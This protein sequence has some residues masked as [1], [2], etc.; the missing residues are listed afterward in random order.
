M[1]QELDILASDMLKGAR[2]IAKFRGE[3]ERRTFDL[4]SRG[5]I[6]GFRLA[7]RWYST[8]SAQRRHLARME[9]EYAAVVGGMR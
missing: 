1:D 9:G 2:Q 3:P 7:G 6:P 4:L 8:R 5:L